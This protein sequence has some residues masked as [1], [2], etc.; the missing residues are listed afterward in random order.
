MDE[1][2]TVSNQTSFFFFG[3]PSCNHC[4]LSPQH[5]GFAHH[6]TL[7]CF[8]PL[9]SRLVIKKAHFMLVFFRA[10]TLPRSY[11]HGMAAALHLVNCSLTDSTQGLF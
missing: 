8:T 2:R 4:A 10:T 5:Y 3:Q 11:D 6:A 7:H 1:R 9:K